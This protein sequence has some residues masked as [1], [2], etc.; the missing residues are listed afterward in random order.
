MAETFTAQVRRINERNKRKIM[1]V[2]KQSAQEVFADAQLPVS[3][4]GRMRVDTGFLRNSLQ[5]S[6]NGSTALSGEEGY[7]LAISQ[8]KAGDR[9][10]GGWTAEYAMARE[11]GARGQLPDFFMRGAAQKWQSIVAKNA[12]LVKVGGAT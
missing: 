7:I 6:L 5:S 2:V 4:G 10:F 1:A 3:Q 9:M 11:F 8:M 12:A